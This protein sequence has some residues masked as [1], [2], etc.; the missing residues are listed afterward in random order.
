MRKITE[1]LTIRISPELKAE[2]VEL[3]KRLTTPNKEV[4]MTD[5]VTPPI[6]REVKRL[7]KEINKMEKR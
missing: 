3:A 5:I 7:K 1:R 2:L 6:E 4:T